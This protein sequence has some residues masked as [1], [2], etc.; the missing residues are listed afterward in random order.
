ML[1]I[2]GPTAS[3]YWGY[4]EIGRASDW[5]VSS[6]ESALGHFTATVEQADTF[7]LSQQGLEVRI[8]RPKGQP[9]RWPVNSL[10]IEGRT[11]SAVVRISEG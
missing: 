1:A 5:S 9:W 11:I 3:I 8:P 7:A 2:T 10:H 6:S 4:R